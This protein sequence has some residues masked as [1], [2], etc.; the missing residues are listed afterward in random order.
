[1]KNLRIAVQKSGRLAEISNELLRECGIELKSS[2]G[3]LLS[4]AANFP[5]EVLYFRD[6]DIPQYVED[7]TADLG[8]LGENVVVESQT[9]IEIV[10]RLGFGKC[11]LSLAV[12]RSVDYEGVQFFAGK[13]VATSYPNICR[14]YLA[15]FGITADIHNISGSVEIAPN[16][17]LADGICDIVSSGGT[18]MS[19][20]LKEVAIIMQS[21]AVLVANPRLVAPQTA[22]EHAAAAILNKISFRL[23][24]V[25]LA[26][27]NKYIVLNAPNEAIESICKILTGM[28]SPTVVPLATQGWSAIH[29]V[30]NEETFW[31]KIE[32][33]RALGAQ[34]ILVVPIEKMIV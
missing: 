26:R 5:I 3:G 15:Q 12:P 18:L 17:G 21:E 2:K 24:A 25:M 16:I 7:G 9:K 32:D 34:G 6:D 27:R 14:N 20:G 10:R 8:I 29:S 30:L 22:D 19:N 1:M 13:K 11:R 4:V 23:D 28:K 31:D 33:L